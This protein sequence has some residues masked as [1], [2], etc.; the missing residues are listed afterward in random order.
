MKEYS[1]AAYHYQ[2]CLRILAVLGGRTYTV[3]NALIW[4]A[5]LLTALHAHEAA[6]ELLTFVALHPET[7]QP[8]RD[9][10]AEKL[11]QLQAQLPPEIF[12][13]A[14][15]RGRQ[16]EL[17]VVTK[18]LIMDLGQL[19]QNSPSAVNELF[20]KRG[21]SSLTMKFVPLSLRELEV[22]RLVAEGRSNQEIADRLFIGVSTVKKHVNHIFDKLDVKNRTQAVA[23][24]RE[25]QLLA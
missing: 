21:L 11:Q 8:D 24:A 3:L 12:A 1:V 9:L 2:Q 18:W 6:I 16:L 14:Q 13:A 25:R 5:V 10:A 17:S 15:D 23:F 22:L 20:T 7:L 4:I 19:A